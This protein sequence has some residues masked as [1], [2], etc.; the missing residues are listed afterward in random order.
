M[1]ESPSRNLGA[2]YERVGGQDEAV[3]EINLTP[4]EQQIL[5]QCEKPATLEAIC[6]ASEEN[7]FEICRLLWAFRTL[8]FVKRI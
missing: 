2:A 3:R 4:N 6:D 8:G 7:D 5:T 1:I